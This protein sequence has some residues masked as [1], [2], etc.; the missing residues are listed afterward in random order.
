MFRPV[1]VTRASEE[2]VRQVKALIFGGRLGPGD[3]LPSER[4]W[5]SSS[6]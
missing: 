6:G 2:V 4:T 5:L 3:P 1:R